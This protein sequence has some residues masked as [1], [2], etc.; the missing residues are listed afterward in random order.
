MVRIAQTVAVAALWVGLAVPAGGDIIGYSVQSDGNDWLYEINLNTGAATPVGPVGFL[1]VEGLCFQP[2][3]GALFGWNDGGHLITIDPAT[4]AGTTVGPSGVSGQFDAGLTFDANGDLFVSRGFT[5]VQ[6][7][8]SVDPLTGLAS[9]IGPTT[10]EPVIALADAGGDM[11]WGVSQAYDGQP[12][13][14]VSVSKSTG[15]TTVIGLMGLG[16]GIDGGVGID[17]GPDGTLWGIAD[18]GAIFTI[19]TITGQATVVATTL[20]G[21]EG[22]AIPEPATVA[23]LALGGLGTLLRKRRRRQR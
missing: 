21:Y 4:G 16:S 17:Y 10:G 15:A 3:T 18:N 8:Y 13:K 9:L 11:L 19:D 12:L 14:F 23:L 20:G 7:L 6:L 1:D 22:L 2:G 5:T